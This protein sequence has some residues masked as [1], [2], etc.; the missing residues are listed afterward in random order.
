MIFLPRP[1]PSCLKG[2]NLD[3]ATGLPH[4]NFKTAQVEAVLDSTGKLSSVRVLDPGAYYYSTPDVFVNGNRITGGELTVT[5]ESIAVSWV[6]ISTYGSGGLGFVGAPGSHVT[7]GSGGTVS[8]GVIA[9]ELGHNFGLLH[10]NTLTSLSEKPNS[11]EAI[12]WEYANEHSVM[13]S[14]GI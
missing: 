13:G 7:A 4:P 11:D 1:P 3:P 8:A 2:G 12:K 5:V 9:H 14:G 6:V 10:S